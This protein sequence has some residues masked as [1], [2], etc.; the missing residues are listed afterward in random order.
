MAAV[1]LRS[2]DDISGGRETVPIAV[3][4]GVSLLNSGLLEF[5]VLIER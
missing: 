1:C 2:H 5:M 3:D 4:G